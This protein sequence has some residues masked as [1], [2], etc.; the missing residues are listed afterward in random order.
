MNSLWK[1]AD[2]RKSI[3]PSV[4]SGEVGS[5]PF[6]SRPKSPLFLECDILHEVCIYTSKTT[7]PYV[8]QD[9]RSMVPF[10]IT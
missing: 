10:L 6:K 8:G 4:S 1:V 2:Y 7:G 3:K 9:T 5:N